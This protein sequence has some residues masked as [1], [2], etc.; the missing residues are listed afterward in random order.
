MVQAQLQLIAGRVPRV[1]LALDGH[2]GNHA[3]LHLAQPCGLHLLS[4]LRADAALYFP[5]DGPYQGRG[6]RRKYGA[7]LAYAAIPEQYLTP[8]TVH[9]TI[10]T[11]I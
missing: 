2:F 8:T 11:H 5:Y 3:A 9:D 10:E 4:K 1:D 6:P 7:K